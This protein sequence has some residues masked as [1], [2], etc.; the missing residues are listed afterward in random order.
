MEHPEFFIGEDAFSGRTLIGD[1]FNE[2]SVS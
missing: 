2:I 1:L